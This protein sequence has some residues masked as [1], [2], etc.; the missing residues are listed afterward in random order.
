MNWPD[1]SRKAALIAAALLVAAVVAAAFAIPTDDRYAVARAVRVDWPMVPESV[2]RTNDG[3][4]VIVG[5]RRAMRVD[6][7]GGIVWRRLFP[8][9]GFGRRSARA[10]SASYDAGVDLPDGGTLLCGTR[11]M[12]SGDPEAPVTTAGLIARIDR[13]GA[14]VERR[15]VFPKGVRTYHS[16]YFHRCLAWAGG[17]AL[18]GE[19]DKFDSA[20]RGTRRS[21]YWLVLLDAGGQLRWERLVPIATVGFDRPAAVVLPDGDLVLAKSGTGGPGSATDIVRIDSGGKVRVHRSVPGRAIPVEPLGGRSDVAMLAEGRERAT[22]TEL[23]DGAGPARAETFALGGFSVRRAYRAPEGALVMI[24]YARRGLVRYTAVAEVAAHGLR[25][26]L[27]RSVEAAPWTDA[28]PT[29]RPDEFA[30]VGDAG[31]GGAH[32]A[33]ALA[34]VAPRRGKLFDAASEAAAVAVDQA[35]VV[36]SDPLGFIA[37]AGA[38]LSDTRAADDGVAR[39]K[40]S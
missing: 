33:L 3:G 20:A 5:A 4:Y 7:D 31:A 13:A 29:G 22:L 27:V 30:V 34:L 17:I 16:S 24:G 19:A 37:A 39:P 18:I 9:D 11:E 38:W 21:F 8:G 36:L 12:G 6:A 14:V 10:P 28:I 1:P 2:T 25:E 40:R 32:R 35:R 26:S 23:G 15:L